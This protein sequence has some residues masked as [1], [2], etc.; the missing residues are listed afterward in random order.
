MA[1][2]SKEQRTYLIDGKLIPLGY[3]QVTTLSASMGLKPP[4]GAR[5]AVIQALAQHVRW[6]DDGEDPTGTI[7]MRLAVGQQML[8]TGS[9]VDIR[10]IEETTSAQLNISYYF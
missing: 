10:F 6:R 3:E 7:G 4:M 5:V 1:I 2:E 8:Y 9:L